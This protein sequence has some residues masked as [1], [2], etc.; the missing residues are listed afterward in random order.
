MGFQETSRVT[1]GNV[2][3]E[4]LVQRL[5]FKGHNAQVVLVAIGCFSHMLDHV[6][7]NFDKP[8][9]SICIY[10]Y[11]GGEISLLIVQRIKL[12]LRRELTGRSMKSL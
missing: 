7:E 3:A 1:P 11:L 2:T 9:L 10:I 5:M 8:V 4:H 6:S 12:D